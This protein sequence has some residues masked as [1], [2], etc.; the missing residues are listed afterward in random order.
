MIVPPPDLPAMLPT[1]PE[2][3]TVALFVLAI[4][5]HLSGN[6]KLLRAVTYQMSRLGW[7]VTPV[8]RSREGV[9]E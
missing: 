4:D 9:A 5:A 8:G 1:G 7:R 6:E 2:L 3:A